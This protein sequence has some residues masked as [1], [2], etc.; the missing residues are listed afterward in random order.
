MD[1]RFKEKL[2]LL[3]FLVLFSS[4]S[5]NKFVV[6]KL[7]DNLASGN[8]TVFTGETDPD[9]VGDAL[10]FALKFYESL[11]EM[12][13]NNEKLLFATGQAFVLYAYAFLQEKAE[14]L[15]EENIEEKNY[16]KKRAKNLYLRGRSYILKALNVRYENFTNLLRTDIEKALKLT[17]KNDVGCLFWA[18]QAWMAAYSIDPFDFE[19][20]MGKSIAIKMILRALQLDDTYEQGMIHN[21]LISY[22]GS[23][24]KDM[25]GSEKKAREHFQK[26]IELSRGL[27]ASPYLSLA[28]S[29]CIKNQNVEEFKKLLNKALEVDVNKDPKNRLANILAQRKAKWLLKHIDDYFLI[30]GE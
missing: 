25:G 7:A 3:S 16:L 30:K 28:T 12:T 19:L 10:P 26:T 13:P 15:P 8:S 11:L 24:P 2:F 22:Y 21:F 9:L 23:L 18:G 6:N 27:S 4:C 29:V 14:M 5:I 1:K 17:T 20:A